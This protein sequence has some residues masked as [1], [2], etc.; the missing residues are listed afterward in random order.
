MRAAVTVVFLAFVLALSAGPGVRRST[1]G[2]T[3]HERPPPRPLAPWPAHLVLMA[4]A[5]V[6]LAPFVWMV[7]RSF[8][9]QSEIFSADLH[10]LPQRWARARTTPRRSTQ[11]PLLRFLLNG[12]IVTAA[13]FSLQVLVSAAGRL[14][15]G[16]AALSRPRRRC[17]A[18]VLL[19]LLIPIHAHRAA[20][21]H[22]VLQAR[23]S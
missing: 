9:P 19:C 21:L 6:M 23:A 1:S 3:T 5:V 22:P 15:A 10:L 16:Q 17:S 11:V 12:V 18:L 13:I 14:C 2:C 4:G 8:K 7:L 20:D